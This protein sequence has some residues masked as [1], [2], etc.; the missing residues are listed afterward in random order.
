MP[1]RDLPARASLENLRK[2]AKTLQR[3]F[4]DG[5]ADAVQRIRDNLPR[6]AALSEKELRAHDLSRQ[7]A[8]HVLAK[9]YGRASW[10]DLKVALS[11]AGFE[12]LARLSDRQAQAVLREV[13]QLDLCR[14]LVGAPADCPTRAR[15]A[16]RSGGSGL[17]AR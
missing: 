8:Q 10:D 16:R 17:P 6:A 1:T 3:V 7:E 9:E 13:S 12:D 2:Q 11:T 4:L 15:A 14:A 5:D